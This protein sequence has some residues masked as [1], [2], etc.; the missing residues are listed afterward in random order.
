MPAEEFLAPDASYLQL[1]LVAG[2][3]GMK[4]GIT[5]H[6]VQKPGL[7]LAGYLKSLRPGRVQILGESEITYLAGLS[8]GL[9]P[10]TKRIR[11]NWQIDRRWE[12]RMATDK[13]NDLYASWRKA[14]NRS[15]GWIE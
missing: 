12:P 11:E 8:A 2:K 3:S 5:S 14:V 4:R 6:R 7:A 9:W 15:F 10:D 13:R 1:R